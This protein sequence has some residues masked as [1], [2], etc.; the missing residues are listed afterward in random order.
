MVNEAKML[1]GPVAF[2]PTTEDDLEFVMKLENDPENISFVRQWPLEQHRS[3]LTDDNIA[4]MIIHTKSDETIIGYIILIGLQS[5]DRSVQ[6]KRIVIARKGEGF[7]RASVRL[8]KRFAFEKLGA[9][10]LWL[11]VVDHNE[12]AYR[13]YK[14]EGFILEG[15]HRESLRQGD[16]FVSVKVMSMLAHEYNRQAVQNKCKLKETKRP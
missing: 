13:L 11:A 4:H 1:F 12:R 5:P 6:F 14:S 7:G 9:H 16:R 3:A 8:L 15:I 10:R 2:R